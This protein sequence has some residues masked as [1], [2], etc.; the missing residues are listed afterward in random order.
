MDNISTIG[1]NCFGCRGCEQACPAHCISI[2]QNEEGF[3]YPVV[4]QEAC[5][6][7]KKCLKVCPANNSDMHRNEATEV[8]AVKNK[9]RN[10]LLKSASGGASDVVVTYILNNGGVAYGAAYDDELIVKHIRVESIEKKDKLQSSKYVQ[11]DIG[12]SYSQARNDL[13]NGKTVLFTGTPCQIEGLYTFLGK[14]YANL[15]TIDLICHGVPSPKLFHIYLQ[16]MSEK[17]DDK[18][19]AYNFRSKQKRGWGTN[20]LVETQKKHKTGPMALDKYGKHFLLGDCYR[21]SCYQCPF[22]NL[23]RPGDITVGDFWGVMKSHPDFYS[24]DGVSSVFINS[25]KGQQLLKMIKESSHILSITMQEGMN[26]QGNLIHPSLRDSNR[27]T[28]YNNIDDSNYMEKLKIGLQLKQRLK[29]MLPT[30]LLMV[31]KRIM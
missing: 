25:T 13:N 21:E 20:Y 5:L 9:I 8:W 18:I 7:C 30:E 4:N 19:V 17:M 15:Y 10:S 31:L 6:N 1:K 3:L 24:K 23:N 12:H 28:I 16:Y 26:K 14:E 11:S 22:A 27:N 2:K 29:S